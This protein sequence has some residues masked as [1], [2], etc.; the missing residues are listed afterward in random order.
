MGVSA[1]LSPRALETE[2]GG[3]VR[4]QVRVR[5]TGSVVDQFVV[6][7]VGAAGPWSSV[8]PESLN[9]L[10]GD[11]GVATVVIKPPRAASTPAGEVAFGVRVFSKEDPSG[12]TVE[13]GTL[14]I[15]PFSE[16]T[17]EV[18][19]HSGRGRRSARYEVAVDNRGNVPL[20]TDL[21]PTDPDQLLKFDV[22]P[23]GL[24]CDPGTATFAKVIV[25][26]KKRF[27][28]GPNKTLPFQVTAAPQGEAPV[29][30]DGVMVQEAIIPRWLPAALAALIALAIVLAILWATLFKPAIQD[31]AKTEANKA[32][33]ATQNQAN[34]ASKQA[35][36]AATSAKKAAD[37]AAS[38][39]ATTVP[40]GVTTTTSP[41]L[42]SLISGGNGTS[43]RLQT[44]VAAAGNQTVPAP[45]PPAGKSFML[46]DMVL[47]NPQ[48]DT[49]QITINR[50][51]P[52]AVLFQVGLGN[53]RDLDYH[54]VSPILFRPGQQLNIQVNCTTPGSGAS[55]C[56]PA[57]S[58]SGVFATL[59]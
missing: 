29:T 35:A 31:A 57:V 5:N 48:G 15:A 39:G 22:R 45:A 19:P 44:S 2:A 53:F 23:P 47:E 51:N 58:F 38:V 27:W 4:C 40:N 18:V 41:S 55:T 17:A 10:P 9:L 52:N 16:L 3:E 33:A 42:N 7:V 28:R 25:R 59:P 56:N 46:T 8:E 49:G 37:A 34:Q 36:A 6:D 54:F 21:L 12:S 43:F 24:K 26:P 14:T 50:T 30:A 1:S 11:E 13:E 20:N 32:L